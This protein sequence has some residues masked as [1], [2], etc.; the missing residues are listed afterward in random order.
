M[1]CKIVI[2]F[3]SEADTLPMLMLANQ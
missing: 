2:I 1:D 3:S